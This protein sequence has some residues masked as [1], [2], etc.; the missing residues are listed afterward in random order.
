MMRWPRVPLNCRKLMI[1]CYYAVVHIT[2][3]RVYLHDRG[4]MGFMALINK[5]V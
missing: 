2:Y 4:E 5:Y 1:F 3:N